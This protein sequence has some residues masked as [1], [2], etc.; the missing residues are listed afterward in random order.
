MDILNFVRNN[1][2]I[3]MKRK[4]DWL[5][6]QSSVVPFIK[7]NDGLKIVLISSLKSKKW[8]VPKGV[9]EK[10]LS[11]Q[12]SA[13]KEALEEAGVEG[14]VGN[15]PIGYFEYEKWGGICKVQVFALRVEKVLEDWAE[16]NYLLTKVFN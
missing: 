3:N 4:P 11:P 15:E 9:I 7:D 13:A 10:P 2:N 6:N 16:K 14:E 5:Y 12:D 8:I 1:F